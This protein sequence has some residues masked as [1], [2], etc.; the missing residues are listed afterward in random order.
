M[1]VDRHDAAAGSPPRRPLRAS[2]LG[3]VYSVLSAVFY[4]LMGIC[5]RELSTI[6]DLAPI[7]VRDRH[8]GR[9]VEEQVVLAD[10]VHV[11][12]ELGQLPGAV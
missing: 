10:V 9:R 6:Q 11:A 4:T 5:Q 12:L 1:T 2:T 7:E 3:M 8:F